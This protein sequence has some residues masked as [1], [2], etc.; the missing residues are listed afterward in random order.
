MFVITFDGSAKPKRAG[1]GFAGILWRLDGWLLKDARSAFVEEATVI[2][3]EYRG[4]FLGLELAA[5]QGVKHVILCGDSN[6]VI[7]QLRGDMACNTPALKVLKMRVEQ[8]FTRFSSI[9]F[10]HMKR[11][12]NQPA[13]LLAGQAMQRGQGLGALAQDIVSDL[14]T[15]NRLPEILDVLVGEDAS[16]D[17]TSP[18]CVRLDASKEISPDASVNREISPDSGA[19]RKISASQV[20]S[21]TR[22]GRDTTVSDIESPDIE[23][24]DKISQDFQAGDGNGTWVQRDNGPLD[25]VEERWR[26]IRV[27][28]DEELW[29]CTM[30]R[31]LRGDFEDLT[32]EQLRDCKKTSDS[33]LIDQRDCLNY[34]GAERRGQSEDSADSLQIR[35][36]VP[37]TLQQDLLHHYHA[38][39]ESGHQGIVRTFAR[40][41]QHFYWRGM[42]QSC[43]RFVTSCLDC[44]TA[45][46]RPNLLIP[47]P[48]NLVAV[49][50]FQIIAMDFIPSLPE[51]YRGNTELLL[52][53]DLHTGF[54]ICQASASRT[55]VTVA[56]IYEEAV[57]RRFGAS[58]QIRHDRE[59]GFMSDFFTEFNRL[60][61]QKQRAT[62]AYRPQANGMAERKVQ[63]ITRAMKIYVSDPE[64]RDW[65]DYAERLGF[66]LNTAVDTTRNETPFFLVHGWDP[67]TTI[68]STLGIAQI[69]A[70]DADSRRWRFGIQ[71][72]YMHARAQANKL[73]KDATDARAAAATRI[74]SPD[75]KIEVGSQV[76]VFLD[77]VRPGF[78]KKL[79]HLWHGPFRV[80]EMIEDHACRLEIAGTECRLLRREYPDRPTEALQ[81]P[82]YGRFDFDE[83]LLPQDSWQ[84]DAEDGIYEVNDILDMRVSN[85][86]R[87]GRRKREYL[88]RLGRGRLSAELGLRDGLNCGA[89]LFEFHERNRGRHRLRAVEMEM[90]RDD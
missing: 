56:S 11:E 23:T 25:L 26:R 47:S 64:Q 38:T 36:V 45:K 3:A 44:E 61:G 37:T 33:F 87:F 60:M 75:P 21:V 57:F 67:R 51:S 27:A 40:L 72:S 20:M 84:A 10:L 48:G 46:G 74:A 16:G 22:S 17:E 53:V 30:K 63:T 35:V 13:D 71:R 15:L 50:P 78:A 41:R 70:Q 85:P 4:A 77:R 88:V 76:W 66:A 14:V 1:G 39:L 86:T 29:I 31:F 7:R 54:A 49:Y 90:P 68:E 89:L 28:Q 5:A 34:I 69:D 2:E 52:F 8:L 59:A 58:E 73:V 62:L 82:D 80:S 65:D 83:A 6:L 32:E 24:P 79:A 55:A 81:A 43:Y 18:D 42:Y 12:F 19:N 9:Q